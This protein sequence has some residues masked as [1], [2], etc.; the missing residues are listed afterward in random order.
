M[1]ASEQAPL[2]VFGQIGIRALAGYLTPI[3]MLICGVLLWFTS[4]ARTYHS[5]LVIVLAM[6]SWLTANLGGFLIGM[7]ISVVGAALAFAWMTDTD[8]KSSGRLRVKAK[9]RPPS[10]VLGVV[11]RL[12][13]TTAIL[14]RHWAAR[15]HRRKAAPSRVPIQEALFDLNIRSDADE[16]GTGRLRALSRPWRVLG[17][18]SRPTAR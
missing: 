2:P 1:L 13:A 10:R 8:Y 3:F 9:V 18:L 14:R 5:L 7:L 12:G 16:P 4:I 6:D 11:S 15:P 17:R